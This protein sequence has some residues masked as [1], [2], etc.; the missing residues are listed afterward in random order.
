MNW[1]VIAAGYLFA[2]SLIMMFLR[3]ASYK[4]NIQRDPNY[5]GK[6]KND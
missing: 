2:V 5:Y 3:G 6:R 4:D 1:I